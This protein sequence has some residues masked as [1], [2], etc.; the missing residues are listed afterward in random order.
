MI[1]PLMKRL[2]ASREPSARCW[3]HASRGAPALLPRRHSAW[4]APPLGRRFFTL[5]VAIAMLLG[6]SMT[7]AARADVVTFA[8]FNQ[9]RVSDQ[10]FAYANSGTSAAFNSA[11][12]GIPIYLSITDGFAPGLDR[13]Q[14]AHLFLTSTTSA[15]TMPLAPPDQLVR[16]H[17]TGTANAIQ[18]LLDTPVNGKRDFLTVTFSDGL[19]SGRLNGTEASLKTSD[20]DSGNPSRVGFLSDFIDFTNAIEH[21]LSLSFSS[22]N[23]TVGGGFL[24]L[25]DNGFLKSFTA[26]GTGTFDTAFPAIATVPEPSSLVLAALGLIGLFSLARARNCRKTS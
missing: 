11:S 7:S 18:I 21:G 26:A 19:L 2:A 9:Q 17:F 1:L 24:Q 15:A 3:R 6:I 23:A 14:L 10:D 25:A 22:V 8:Q 13:L 16:E 12:Q 20:T 4:Q 5:V